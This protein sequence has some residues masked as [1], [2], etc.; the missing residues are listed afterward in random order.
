MLL[1]ALAALPPKEQK[2]R[3]LEE[4][5]ARP[6]EQLAYSAKLIWED[7]RNRKKESQQ[8]ENVQK[9]LDLIS[10]HMLEVRSPSSIFFFSFS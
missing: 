7:L 6:I 5:R 1:A 4:K 9:L 2:Q 3:R 8:A 10:G